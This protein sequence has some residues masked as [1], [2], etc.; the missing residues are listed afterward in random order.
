MAVR[1]DE[2]LAGILGSQDEKIQPKF[3]DVLAKVPSADL[4]RKLE[5]IAKEL[6]TAAVAVQELNSRNAE[7]IQQSI[8]MVVSTIA[9]FRS[10][11]GTE[12][13]TYSE[14]GTLRSAEDPAFARKNTTIV[15]DA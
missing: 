13:P 7:L 8:G 2:V 1:R 11:P 12:L 14:S 10:A 9:I 6:K 3:A 15:R 4:R 5:V